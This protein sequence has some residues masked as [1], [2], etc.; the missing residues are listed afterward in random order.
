MSMVL[1]YFLT[2][3]YLTDT[4]IGTELPVERPL[5]NNRKLRAFYLIHMLIQLVHAYRS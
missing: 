2:L 1:F 3:V 4:F 5:L